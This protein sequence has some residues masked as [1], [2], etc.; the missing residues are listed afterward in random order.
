MDSTALPRHLVVVSCV[1]LVVLAL[2]WE[3]VLAPQRPGGSLL[4][5]KALPLAASLPALARGRIRMF[6][7]WSMGILGYLC[8]GVVRGMT[9]AN[10]TSR[11]L[12][13]IEC[14]LATLAWF[15][16]LAT[17]RAARRAAQA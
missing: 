2:A 8:E 5:L 17:V 16:I 1:A 9:D 3:T 4:A 12:G 11:L 14:G 13:W 6:Q 15:A 7:W 10:A